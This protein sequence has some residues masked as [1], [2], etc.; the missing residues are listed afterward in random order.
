MPPSKASATQDKPS[1]VSSSSVAV[2]PPRGMEVDSVTWDSLNALA[3]MDI[4]SFA[5]GQQTQQGQLLED[6]SRSAPAQEAALFDA[7][8]KNSIQDAKAALE[9]GA[10]PNWREPTPEGWSCLHR[11]LMSG[12]RRDIVAMLLMAKADVNAA[13]SEGRTALHLSMERYLYLSPVIFRMLLDH[14][15]DIQGCDLKSRTPLDYAKDIASTMQ[16]HQRANSV[17]SRA[18]IRQLLH[19]LTK[20][21][22]RAIHVAEGDVGNAFFGDSD[23]KLIVYNTRTQIG[24]FDLEQKRLIAGKRLQNSDEFIIQ[25]IAVNPLLGVIAACV[26]FTNRSVNMQHMVFVWAHGMTNYLNDEPLGLSIKATLGERRFGNMAICMSKSS[27][28][29]TP[30]TL[31]ARLRDGQVFCWVLD[32]QC[33]RVNAE[34]KLSDDGS[35]AAISDDGQWIAVATDVKH[36][37][38]G[39]LEVFSLEADK[40]GAGDSPFRLCHLE[41]KQS[42]VAIARVSADNGFL[43]TSS[44]GPNSPAAVIQVWSLPEV[45]LVHELAIDCHCRA[46]VFCYNQ[47]HLLLSNH[48]DGQ[49][50]LTDLGRKQRATSCDELYIRS[51]DVSCDTKLV[52]STCNDYLRVYNSPQ[53]K[54]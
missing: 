27:N 49:V 3:D 46:L 42:S 6:V 11:A 31:V 24:I 34:W 50:V 12:G 47:P 45:E 36:S 21:P 2:V 1:N 53:F 15:A 20:H 52:V 7:V 40:I 28:P 32:A 51:I 10:D 18:K 41:E 48:D 19:E 16:L 43:A 13:D 8:K 30:T 17:S 5:F 37:P 33:T 54:N 35:R 44:H 4:N 23:A 14:Q 38:S 26:E 39:T 9:A 29:K 22:T 25:S